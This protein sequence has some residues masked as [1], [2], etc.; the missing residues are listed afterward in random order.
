MMVKVC[1]ITNEED[2]L[3]AVDYGA[4]ALGF[5]FYAGSPRHV[6]P[7]AAARII[8]Q[9]PAGIWKVGVFVD[10]PPA[11]V[12]AVAGEAG[13]DVAQLHGSETVAEFPQGIRVW[14]ALRIAGSLPDLEL[15]PAEAILLDGAA[16]GQTFDWNLARGAAG[17]IILAGG[18]GPENV[19]RAIAQAQPWGVDASS[20]IERAPGRK[21]H[22]RMAAFIRAALDVQTC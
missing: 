11:A 21:D 1:G 17:R 10:E 8:E 4:A 12:A 13:L 16:S 20:A 2:A 6:N 9:V 3:A 5:I 19:R 15:Y 14:K 22:V 7:E 18:L